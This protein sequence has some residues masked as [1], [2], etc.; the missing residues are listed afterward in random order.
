MMKLVSRRAQQG[1][2]LAIGLIML[3]VITVMV[4]AAFKLSTVNLAAVGNMQFREQA[5]AAGNLVINREADAPF[6]NSGSVAIPPRTDVDIDGDG[7]AD[8]SVYFNGITC[9]QASAEGTTAA[10]SVTLPVTMTTATAYNTV[11]DFDVTVRDVNYVTAGETT[12][13]SV[14]IHQGVAVRLTQA[15]CNALCPPATG[16]A[17]S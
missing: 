8:F 17:C 16:T 9:L 2:T 11:W 14:R 5:I 6:Q 1:V 3:V 15:Q 10:S 4:V 7:N 12:G 13:T